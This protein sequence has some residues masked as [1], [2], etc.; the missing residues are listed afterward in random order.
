MKMRTYIKDLKPVIEITCI[1]S[2]L[3][4]NYI[5]RGI[6]RKNFIIFWRRICCRCMSQQDGRDMRF[7]SIKDKDSYVKE[8]EIIM[9]DN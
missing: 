4:R 8:S 5:E 1:L 9:M 2:G 6:Q 3:D 7:G